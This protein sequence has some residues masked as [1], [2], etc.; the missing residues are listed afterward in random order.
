MKLESIS[1]NQNMDGDEIKITASTSGKDSGVPRKKSLNVS[2][3]AKDKEKNERTKEKQIPA[4]RILWTSS[5]C[6]RLMLDSARSHSESDQH[7]VSWDLF[8]KDEGYS[9]HERSVMSKEL[10]KY[11][12][13]IVD[14]LLKMSD[15]ERSSLMKKDT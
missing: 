3:N 1:I 7:G 11:Q 13:V 2:A 12:S 6:T 5:G 15:A 14:G 9:V 8:L 10:D 4:K